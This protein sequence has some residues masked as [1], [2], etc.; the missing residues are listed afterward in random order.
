L[1][2]NLAVIGYQTTKSGALVFC[3]KLFPPGPGLVVTF[4]V[5][6]TS[7]E[8]NANASKESIAKCSGGK[9]A[10]RLLRDVWELVI[11]KVIERQW[12]TSSIY[13]S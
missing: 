6:A 12:V 9:L 5:L 10:E 8:F 2:G 13:V 4:R 1:C 7:P 3:G 11:P